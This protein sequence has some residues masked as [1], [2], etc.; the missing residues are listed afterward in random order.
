MTKNLTISEW[1][2]AN[3]DKTQSDL[4]RLVNKDRRQIYDAM[5]RGNLVIIN[6]IGEYLLVPARYKRAFI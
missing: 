4:A 2:T 3:P 6:S 1:L 5:A